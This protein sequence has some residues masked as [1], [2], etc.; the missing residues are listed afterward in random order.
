[1]HEIKATTE[2]REPKDSKSRAKTLLFRSVPRTYTK[3]DR[4]SKNIDELHD[5]LKLKS[6]SSKTR[7]IN[8]I[9]IISFSGLTVGYH[10]YSAGHGVDPAGG[11]PGGG[12]SVPCGGRHPTA[13][14][15]GVQ[16]SS[17]VCGQY[18]HFAR[19]CPLSGSQHTAAPPQGHGGS[20]KGRSFPAQQQWLGEPNLRPFQQPGPSRF[21]LSS[22]PQFS[23]PQFA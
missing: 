3:P 1:M 5:L 16:G 12:S 21:G 22:H 4:I 19:V 7:L 17:N 13:Q 23:G 2:H 14:C 10:G 20:S 11:A 6:E 15:V 9:N 18:G 8:A